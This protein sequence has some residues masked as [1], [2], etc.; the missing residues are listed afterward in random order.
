ME[1]NE[2]MKVNLAEIG[3]GDN[4][5]DIS[6]SADV[7]DCPECDLEGEILSFDLRIIREGKESETEG[8]AICWCSCGCVWNPKSGAH[9]NTAESGLEYND[10]EDI[11]ELGWDFKEVGIES[12]EQKKFRKDMVKADRE[13]E[14]YSGRDFYRGWATRAKDFNN[15]QRVIRDTSVPLQWDTLG[16]NSYIVYPQ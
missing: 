12:K 6:C 8:P 3:L 1:Y 11:A 5:L 2:T 4:N 7:Y 14:F 10:I 13:F 15:L 16:K 9:W